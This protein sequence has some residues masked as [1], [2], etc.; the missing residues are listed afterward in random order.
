ME[1]ATFTRVNLSDLRVMMAI[2]HVFMEEL[3][4]PTVMGWI[5]VLEYLLLGACGHLWLCPIMSGIK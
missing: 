3:L 1:K 4:C 2:M 5:P